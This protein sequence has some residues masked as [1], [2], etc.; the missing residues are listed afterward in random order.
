MMVDEETV[1]ALYRKLLNLYPRAFRE[2]LGESMEQTFHDLCNER[3]QRTERGLLGFVLWLFVETG[4]GI[5]KEHV[6]L[7][8]QGNRMKKMLNNPRSAA[9]ISFILALPLTLLFLISVLEV[10]PFNGLLQSLFTAA[11]GYRQNAFGLVVLLGALLLLPVGFLIN[12]RGMVARADSERATAFRL[13]PAHLIIGGSVL[14]VVLITWADGVLYELRPFVPASGSGFIVGR[15]LFFL[16]LLALPVAFLLN[17]PGRL[18]RAGPGGVRMFRP[19][20]INLIAGAAILLIILMIASTFMLETI[21][22]SS[23]V[24]NCD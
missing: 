16:G 7:I 6:L 21:A 5:I 13:T 19:T 14:L 24:P 3:K 9:I 18:A 15:V 8:G 12:L 4:M 20:S 2:Q 11:D 17:L 23:G 22:C 10:E 1:G